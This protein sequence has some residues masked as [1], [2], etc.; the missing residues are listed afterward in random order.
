MTGLLAIGH[1]QSEEDGDEYT[2]L[3]Y[4]CAADHVAL[5]WK[6]GEKNPDCP[7]QNRTGGFPVCRSSRNAV[8]THTALALELSSLVKLAIE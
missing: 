6:K 2:A 3:W 4:Y 5:L 8:K 7:T 1:V